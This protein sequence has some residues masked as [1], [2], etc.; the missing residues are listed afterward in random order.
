VNPRPLLALVCWTALAAACREDPTEIVVYINS[1]VRDLDAVHLVLRHDGE[2]PFFDRR[3]PL[4][5]AGARQLPGEVTVTA[6]TPDDARPIRIEVTAD[7]PR[8]VL[9]YT[10]VMTARFRARATTWVDVFLPDR[11]T[12]PIARVCP[13]GQVCGIVSCEP[14]ERPPLDVPPTRDAGADASDIVDA[15]DASDVADASDITDTSDITDVTDVPDAPRR[16]PDG[17]LPAAEFCYNGLDENCD[18]RADEGCAS[19]SCPADGGVPGCGTHAMPGTAAPVEIGEVGVAGADPPRRVTLRPFGIDRYEVTV[20]R[21]R[22]FWDAGHPVPSSGRVVYSASATVTIPGWAAAN[23]RLVGD[24]AD[25]TGYPYCSLYGSVPAGSPITCVDWPTAMAF[26]V[27]DG[28]RLPT[29]AEWEY[30]ARYHEAP[31]VT[32]PGRVYPWGDDAPAC[33]ANHAELPATCPSRFTHPWPGGTNQPATGALFDLAGN[34]SEWTADGFL[35]FGTAPC[36][37]GFVRLDDPVCLMGD[38]EQRTLRGGSVTS[39]AANMRAA[40]RDHSSATG[41]GAGR[42]FRCI[43]LSP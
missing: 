31:G 14:A 34:V 25:P 15:A 33:Q 38:G 40:A 32:P 16:C 8:D 1:D 27:W 23:P 10:L 28:G 13:L 39:R 19:Q 4:R 7:S 20:E 21:F 37:G 22:R 41:I 6:K 3:Y 12:D 30:A 17:S 11:C 9:D 43:H 24:P 42:G 29:E 2:A 36:W 26:C 18:G 35:P 5:G